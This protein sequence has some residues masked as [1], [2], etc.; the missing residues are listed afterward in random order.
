[1][2]VAQTGAEVVARA[3]ALGFH[4]RLVVRLDPLVSGSH[5]VTRE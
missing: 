5:I 2:L 4:A 3:K 1:M